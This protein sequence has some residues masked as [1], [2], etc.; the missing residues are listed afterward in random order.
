MDCSLSDE[1]PDG[2]NVGVVVQ[3]RTGSSRLPEK[4]LADVYGKSLLERQLYRLQSC[5]RA[6]SI[7]VATSISRAD[8]RIADVAKTMGV[9]CF[10]GSENHVLSRF[11]YAARANKLDVIVRTNADCPFIDPIIIDKVIEKFLFSYPSYDYVSNILED[12]FP[13]GMHVEVF[14]KSALE[15]AFSESTQPEEHEHVT[16]YI[17]RHKELFKIENVACDENLSDYRWTVDYPEDLEFVRAVYKHFLNFDDG[18]GMRDLVN[19]LR[20]NPHLQKINSHYKKG[21]KLM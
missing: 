7:I 2:L 20:K 8:D 11:V 14:T 12:T 21:Q 4:V 19:F 18:F 10:R 1:R 5:K 17:Y 6:S 9:E 16:A 13:L 15:R 3:A